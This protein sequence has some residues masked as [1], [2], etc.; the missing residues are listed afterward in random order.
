MSAALAGSIRDTLANNLSF[1]DPTVREPE[2]D[3]VR[4]GPDNDAATERG[5]EGCSG[6]DA[7]GAG[8]LDK[9]PGSAEFKDCE[10]GESEGAISIVRDGWRSGLACTGP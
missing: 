1:S 3:E 2:G 4:G 6:L 5:V 7:G 9:D 8:V 10:G